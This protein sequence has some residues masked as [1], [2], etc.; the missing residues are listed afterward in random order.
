MSSCTKC[1]KIRRF[2]LLLVNG[3][4][5]VRELRLRRKIRQKR[6][7]MQKLIKDEP[8]HLRRYI[9]QSGTIRRL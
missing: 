7:R 1:S 6:I 4:P 2:L 8:K 5:F 9:M 3:F